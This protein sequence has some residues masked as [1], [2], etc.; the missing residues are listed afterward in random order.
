[1]P[2]FTVRIELHDEYDYAL[3]HGKMEARGFLRTITD[4][5]TGLRYHL[6]NAEYNYVTDEAVTRK[7]ILSRAKAA[8][9]EMFAEDHPGW[10]QE[11]I[12]QHY[13]VLVTESAGRVWHNL[14]PVDEEE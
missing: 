1:M 2:K 4:T 10:S 7:R 14:P 13:E 11:R 6:P 5:S 8:V 3:L 12:D 9:R